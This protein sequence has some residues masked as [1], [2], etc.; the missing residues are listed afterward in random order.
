MG[1]VKKENKER[2]AVF[3]TSFLTWAEV[4]KTRKEKVNLMRFARAKATQFKAVF[5]GF[6][7]VA[8]LSSSAQ[9]KCKIEGCKAVVGISKA[10]GYCARHNPTAS[11]CKG[12]TKKGEPCKQLVK[13][14]ATSC[15]FH[16]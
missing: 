1:I 10:S 9:L 5:L 16:K 12:K 4:L 13:H 2:K 3:I 8:S 6:F 11:H 14:G 15:R 7:I